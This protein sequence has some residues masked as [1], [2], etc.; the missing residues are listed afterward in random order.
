MNRQSPFTMWGLHPS[1]EWAHVLIEVVAIGL[2]AAASWWPRE[3]TLFAMAALSAAVMLALQMAGTYWA[4]TYVVW[5]AAPAWGCA[6]AQYLTRGGR[7]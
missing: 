6:L 3:R 7:A 1:F 2:V 4:H 5:F